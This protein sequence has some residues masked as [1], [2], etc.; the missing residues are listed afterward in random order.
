MPFKGILLPT[1]CEGWI[2]LKRITLADLQK[3]CGGYVT[4]V[5]IAQGTLWCPDDAIGQAQNL[6]TTFIYRKPLWG[7]VVVTGGVGAKGETLSIHPTQ[8]RHIIKHIPLVKRYAT[9]ALLEY[10]ASI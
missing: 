9:P 4:V 10:I 7:N 1:D 6:Y 8:V 3:A 2:P 5:S